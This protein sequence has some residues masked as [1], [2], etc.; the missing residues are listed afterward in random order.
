MLDPIPMF[1][2]TLNA[3]RSQYDSSRIIDLLSK[4]VPKDALVFIGITEKDLYSPGLNFVFAERVEDA[5]KEALIPLYIVRTRDRK[6]D[7]A[8]YKAER[9]KSERPE[10]R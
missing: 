10:Q 8:E 2:Q 7:E 5:W 1:E 6:Y 9:Q 4:R 3:G